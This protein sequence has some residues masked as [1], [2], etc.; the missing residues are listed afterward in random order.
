MNISHGFLVTGALY[1][2]VG[3]AFGIH[4][5]ASGDHTRSPVHAHIN[6]LGF[7]LMT[8]FGLAYR[9]I[10][11]SIRTRWRWRISGCIR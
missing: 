7:T 5:G 1:L 6:L 9:L 11:H 8:L 3:L 2:L 4:M 10:R